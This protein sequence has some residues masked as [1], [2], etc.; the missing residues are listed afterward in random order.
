MFSN[1]QHKILYVKKH[2]QNIVYNTI[3]Y[4]VETN[5]ENS[6]K[7]IEK[8]I[9]N[10]KQTFN[11]KNKMLKTINELFNLDFRIK[12]KNKNEM[13]DEFL[14]RFNNLITFVKL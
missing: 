7:T 1:E 13:F 12:F 3:K 2:T 11:K 4:R 14:I 6:Y 5:S 9:Q 10:L 8:F